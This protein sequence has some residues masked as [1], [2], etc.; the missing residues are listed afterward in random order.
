MKHNLPKR[1]L[2]RGSRLLNDAPAG[3]QASEVGTIDAF[4]SIKIPVGWIC[5]SPYRA[6]RP[7]RLDPSILSAMV[8]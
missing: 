2:G 7:P 3:E 8:W 6:R 5:D 1:V 4:V